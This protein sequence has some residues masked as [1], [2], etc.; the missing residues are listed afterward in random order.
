MHSPERW[1]YLQ[2]ADGS[3]NGTSP[4]R[5]GSWNVREC[6]MDLYFGQKRH[7]QVPLQKDDFKLQR[8]CFTLCSCLWSKMQGKTSN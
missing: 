5:D 7:M 1:G 2:F 8:R 6:A 4:V 3:V